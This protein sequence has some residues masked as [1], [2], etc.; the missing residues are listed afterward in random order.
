M[1]G[2]QL[3]LETLRLNG[4]TQIF[5]NPGTSELWFITLIPTEAGLLVV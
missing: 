4:V 5:G 1:I 3:L 2:R